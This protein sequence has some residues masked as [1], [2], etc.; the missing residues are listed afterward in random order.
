MR[1]VKYVLLVLAAFGLL[2]AGCDREIT[3]DVELADQSSS[4]C[5][6]C[7]SDSDWDV[8]HAQDQFAVSIHATGETV[9]RNRLNRS[10]YQA[11]EKC[12]THEGHVAD[13]AGME[14]DGDF[15]TTIDCFTCHEPHTAGNL[16]LR[17]QNAV[18][19]LDGTSF[20]YG[21]ANQC[22]WCHQS[23]ENVNEFVVAPVE[24][25]L[26]WGPHH[27]NHADM[28]L[29][30]N[31]YEYDGFTYGN[32][33]HNVAV[34][35]A[36]VTCHMSEVSAWGEV[37]GHTFNMDAD[38]VENVGVCVDCH[39][40]IG[41]DEIDFD[42]P[43]DYDG[44]GVDEGVQTEIRQLNDSLEVLLVAAGL[45]LDQHPTDVITN[46][47]SAGAV[48]NYLFVHEDRSWGIHNAQYARDLMISSINY[49]L[50]GNPNGTA[51]IAG[52]IDTH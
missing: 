21:N 16:S 44:D 9:E 27:S 48:F 5:F 51:V 13:V 25:S 10:F 6:E 38:G 17:V 35:G 36:C 45:L 7:H 29:G 3:G 22:A 8:L 46:A 39:S 15:F 40:G 50:T 26:R 30:T 28:F 37:G 34:S 32:S 11:C 42:F 14:A 52:P 23:R 47:D 49:M 12:H 4:N 41:L 20:D 33:G 2:V 1:N 43:A 24:L 31:A 18:T 19:I